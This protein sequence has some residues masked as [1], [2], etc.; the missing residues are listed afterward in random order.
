MPNPPDII[1]QPTG[2]MNEQN[3]NLKWK[4]EYK[5]LAYV[6]FSPSGNYNKM[7]SKI[8]TLISVVIAVTITTGVVVAIM[9]WIRSYSR[10]HHDHDH[11]GNVTTLECVFYPFETSPHP[12][13]VLSGTSSLLFPTWPEKV[14]RISKGQKVDFICPGKTILIG[15]IHLS[16]DILV[17]TCFS[18]SKFQ[19]DDDLVEWADL[20]CNDSNWR[21]IRNTGNTCARDGKEL[22]TGFAVSDGRFIR[23]LTICFNSAMQIAYYTYINQT[24]A[25]S[26]RKLDNV[27][28]IFLQGNVSYTIG[29]VTNL[30][31]RGNQRTTVNRLLNLP[32]N[33]ERYIQ[34]NSDFFLARG[35]M[36][37]RSDGYYA[38]QQNATFYMQNIAP[39][40]QKFNARNWNQIE[41]DVRDYAAK[42]GV[43]LQVW[44]GVYGVTTLPNNK[45]GEPTELYLFVNG[46]SKY[47]PVPEIFWKVAYEPISERGVAL[48]GVNNPYNDTFNK[49]CVDV[50]NKLSWLHCDRNNQELGF[51]YA[52][53]IT[54]L[55]RVV[56]YI[57]HVNEKGLLL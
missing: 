9:Y 15:K 14:V 16:T 47:L 18:G 46:T 38:A 44:T 53:S 6:L 5:N 33:S 52:C 24:S 50:S 19:I 40:W 2:D 45:T 8:V 37:A 41:I 4:K 43:D 56:T 31:K 29:N 35:H 49:L 26:E 55:R 27:R 32:D 48:I 13:F 12:L 51:C 23:T 25:I 10:H 11:G 54:N 1:E 21:D 42:N 39:Q 7:L 36:T 30:Y 17:G 3:T 22:E 28:P 57:P 20:R 34:N